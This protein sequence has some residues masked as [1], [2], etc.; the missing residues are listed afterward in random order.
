MVKLQGPLASLDASGTIAK[1]ITVSKWKGRHYL[2]AKNRPVDPATALQLPTR[3]AMTWLAAEWLLLSDEER[4]SWNTPATA[5][6]LPGYNAF[7]GHNLKRILTHRGPTKTWPAAEIKWYGAWLPFTPWLL[8]AIHAVTLMVGF[9][10]LSDTW[11]ILIFLKDLAPEA[12]GV[13]RLFEIAS[14]TNETYNQILLKP[15]A[16]GPWQ[17]G[18]YPFSID[19]RLASATVTGIANSLDS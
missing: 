15:L 7:I 1:A 4:Q 8:D 13:P 6:E 14:I 19:G 18:I 11:G 2:K 3:A 5:P 16:V 10:P 9:T 12:D 17:G